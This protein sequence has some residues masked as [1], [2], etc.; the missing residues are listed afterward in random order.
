MHCSNWPDVYTTDNGWEGAG[1][2]GGGG[3]GV[4]MPNLAE[5]QTIRPAPSSIAG[6]CF[7]TSPVRT[8]PPTPYPTPTPYTLPYTL[9]LPLPLPGAARV[10]RQRNGLVG[11]EAS[12]TGWRCL[13][14]PPPPHTTTT[15]RQPTMT[16]AVT[17]VKYEATP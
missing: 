5:D 9:P 12:F 10:V 1:A 11:M 3:V 17:E 16:F 4:G 8:L 15:I 6:R 13:P 14:P 2:G 7:P